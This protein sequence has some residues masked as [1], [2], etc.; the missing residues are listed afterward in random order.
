MNAPER[1]LAVP[2][3]AAL[4]RTTHWL[5]RLAA[6]RLP[7]LSPPHTLQRLLG[8]NISVRDLLEWIEADPPL[9]VEVIVGACNALRPSGKPLQGLQHAVNLL[10]I[11]RI[12]GLIRA[13]RDR[14]LDLAHP[15]HQAVLQAMAT[16]RLA[17][18]FTDHWTAL[19]SGTDPEPLIWNT[20]LLGVARWK[21]PLAAPNEAAEIERW[22]AAGQHRATA[23]RALL[24]ITLDE[25]I[26]AHLKAL[27][28]P[29][30]APPLPP[31]L[32]AEAARLAWTGP[33]APEVPAAC[34]Q[35]LQQPGAV[36]GI[37]QGLAQSVQDSWYSARTRTW[38]AVA[39]VHMNQPL[40]RLRADLL[41]L[42]L[43]A[44]Q[45]TSF[46]RSLVAPAARLLWAPPPPRRAARAVSVG[47]RTVAPATPR[48]RS[49]GRI[50]P[51]AHAGLDP[52]RQGQPQD[53]RALFSNTLQTLTQALGLRRCAL[54]LRANDGV[55]LG[56]VFAHGFDGTAVVRGQSFPLEDGQLP[57]RMMQRASAFLWVRDTQAGAARQQLPAVLAPLVLDSG[58]ALAV[59]DVGGQPKGLWWVDTGSTD[60]PLDAATCAAFQKFAR[61]FGADFARLTQAPASPRLQPLRPAIAEP[62]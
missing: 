36:C 52:P 3:P 9:A 15:A 57:H 21:L 61:T 14:P 31:R 41:Q 49:P 55:R 46:T 32:L 40:A 38:M 50:E 48:Q 25:L 17:C 30:V 27:G 43:H 1:N 59:V 19:H 18:L 58:L 12:Q 4:Q 47:P 54:F 42:A 11:E 5:E 56:C 28:L 34:L 29:P 22:V 6:V 45:E 62:A 10:G 2:S 16:S 24:G 44:S 7:L 20:A 37:A 23:E 13:R 8:A 51:A 26:P 35:A 33:V 39:A 53:L 60:R